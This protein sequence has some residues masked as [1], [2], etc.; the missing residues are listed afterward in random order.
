MKWKA[1]N[2]VCDWQAV[3]DNDQHKA[4]GKDAFVMQYEMRNCPV[5]QKLTLWLLAKSKKVTFLH[6]GSDLRKIVI[7]MQC[8][9]PFP[10]ISNLMKATI[11]G[12]WKDCQ[13]QRAWLWC[14]LF[15]FWL[16][17]DLHLIFICND[18]DQVFATCLHLPTVL[19]TL[20]PFLS[21]S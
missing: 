20:L 9:G 12:Q 10:I 7:K 15:S 14:Y 13:S 1:F 18:F 21:T 3:N 16:Y 11:R 5:L 8:V 6:L 2:C 17:K 19:G 4:K